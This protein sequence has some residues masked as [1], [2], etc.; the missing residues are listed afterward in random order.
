MPLLLAGAAWLWCVGFGYWLWVTP[1][2]VVEQHMESSSVVSQ[3][4]SPAPTTRSTALVRS[5]SFKELSGPVPLVIPVVLAGLAF[6][7]AAMKWSA[8][9]GGGAVLLLV[10]AVLTAFSVGL[11]YVPAAAA[12]G[13]A[14]AISSATSDRTVA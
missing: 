14:W 9:L 13:G 1:V 10:F 2:Q 7:A 3:A 4:S 5:R 8:A 12:L 6:L 11:G